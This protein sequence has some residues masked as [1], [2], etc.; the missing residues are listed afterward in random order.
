MR[1][2]DE[3]NVRILG[4]S[5]AKLAESLLRNFAREML[6]TSKVVA[7]RANTYMGSHNVLKT[8]K[9]YTFHRGWESAASATKEHLS[10]ALEPERS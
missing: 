4:G 10:Q 5:V 3:I 9:P 8:I 1:D 7:G 6:T 2:G